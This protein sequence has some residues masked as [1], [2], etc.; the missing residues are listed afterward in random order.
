MANY[1]PTRSKSASFLRFFGIDQN[2]ASSVFSLNPPGGGFD[3]P[4]HLKLGTEF[5]VLLTTLMT[6]LSLLAVS[7]IVGLNHFSHQWVAG[8]ENNL[9]IEIPAANISA[10]LIARLTTELKKLP[11][12]ADARQVQKQEMSEMLSPWLGGMDEIWND[13]PIPALVDVELEGRD[14]GVVEKITALTHA[15]MPDARVDAHESWLADLLKI[16]KAM[17][18]VSLLVF[19]LILIV[20]S[21][22]MSGAVRTRMAIHTR[23]LELLHIMGAS[24]SYISGQFTRY[25]LAQSLRGLGWGIVLGGLTLGGFAALTL[26]DNPGTLPKLILNAQDYALFVAIPMLLFAIAGVTAHITARR[27]LDEMP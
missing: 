22:V 8:L 11:Q 10:P 27:V 17:K 2:A 14:H 16:A 5:L 7:F 23:E 20:T 25:I 6:F 9:T 12:V 4:L 1:D 21:A 3:I 24:D 13:L 18:L 26:H 15:M 19:A